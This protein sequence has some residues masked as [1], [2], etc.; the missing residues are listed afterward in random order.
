MATG[1]LGGKPWRRGLL[2]A[3]LVLCVAVTVGCVWWG[4]AAFL[5]SGHPPETDTDRAERVAGLDHEQHPAKGRYYVPKDA[6]LARAADG[7]PVAYLHYGID[8]DDDATVDDFLDTYDLPQ[9][10]APGPLPADLRA[11]LPGDEPAEGALVPEGRAGRQIFVVKRPSGRRGAAD[12]YVRA[13][14]V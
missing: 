13:S 3:F 7:S 1:G 5:R 12:V 2:G 14:G 11:A 6:V 10:G 4:V 8:G 9:P